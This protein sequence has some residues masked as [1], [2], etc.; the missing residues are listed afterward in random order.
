[1]R[2]TEFG[3]GVHTYNKAEEGLPLGIVP[4]VV[5]LYHQGIKNG[6]FLTQ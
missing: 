3:A 6:Y 4:S 1:V 5:E 2:L